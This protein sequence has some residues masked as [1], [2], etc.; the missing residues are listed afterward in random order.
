ML[1]KAFFSQNNTGNCS[2]LRVQ[3]HVLNSLFNKFLNLG[4]SQTGFFADKLRVKLSNP[5]C[6]NSQ[7]VD[8]EVFGKVE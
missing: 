8:V 2:H 3:K 6:Q 1:I 4:K 5:V 7:T